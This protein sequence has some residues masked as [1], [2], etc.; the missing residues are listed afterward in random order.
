MIFLL[1]GDGK[2]NF[3][4]YSKLLQTKNNPYFPTFS[5]QTE[6]RM[7]RLTEQQL[8]VLEIDTSYSLG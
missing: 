6:L 1:K 2:L 8:H 7:T 5:G 3:V 4:L